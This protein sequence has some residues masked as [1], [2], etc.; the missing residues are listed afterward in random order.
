VVLELE[1]NYEPVRSAPIAETSDREADLSKI[2]E[3]VQVDIRL[4]GLPTF[5]SVASHVVSAASGKD[6]DVKSISSMVGGDP[7]LAADVLFLANSSLFG[8]PARIGSLRHAVAVLGL[9]RVR[10]LAAAVAMR[11]LVREVGPEIRPCWRHSIACAAIAEEIAPLFGCPQDH[12]F[13]AGLLHDIGRFGF[14]KSYAAEV[15]PLLAREFANPDELIQAERATVN[16]DHAEA[17]SWLIQYWVLPEWF[18]EICQNHHAPLAAGDSQLLKAIKVACWMATALGYSSVV[19]TTGP[20]L[21]EVVASLPE[22]FRALRALSSE[23]LHLRIET[24]LNILDS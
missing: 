18:G 22:E 16:I 23:E 24:R 2:T 11:G 21:E 4:C 12:A 3:T 20:T 13:T 1:Q 5:H 19:Y 6:P 9:N 10:D 15:R 7:A 17:G 14:L 8:F